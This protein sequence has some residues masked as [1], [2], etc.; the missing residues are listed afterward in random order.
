M[1]PLDARLDPVIASERSSQRVLGVVGVLM[2]LLGGIFIA[3]V[4]TQSKDLGNAVAAVVFGLVFLVPGAFM[5]RS[6][7]RGPEKTTIVRLLTEDRA[8]LVGWELE[9][10]SINN[11]PTQT[12]IVLH[13]RSGMPL[14]VTLEPATAAPVI[15]YVTDIAPRVTTKRTG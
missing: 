4:A 6:W 13:R 8:S 11:G 15:A 10:V 3:V 14:N 1:T 9:Y 12:R 7:I 5:I 2:A